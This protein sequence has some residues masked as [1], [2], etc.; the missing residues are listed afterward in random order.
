MPLTQTAVPN[1]PETNQLLNDTYTDRNSTTHTGIVAEDNRLRDIMASIQAN[2]TAIVSSMEGTLSSHSGSISGL[3][4]TVSTLNGKVSDNTTDITTNANDILALSQRL[5][6]DIVNVKSLI[7][8]NSTDITTNS[9]AISTINSS[10]N[11]L[12][13]LVQ[14]MNSAFSDAM[15]SDNLRVSAE[16]QYLDELPSFAGAA[17][18]GS[19]AIV[20]H[21]TPQLGDL[22]YQAGSTNWI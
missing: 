8:Q 10:L 7:T 6:E 3:I 9:D 12:Q 15:A 1:I 20:G 22:I 2:V 17:E 5:D 18:Q 4:S 11:T 14:E 13:S 21:T 16:Y 19:F